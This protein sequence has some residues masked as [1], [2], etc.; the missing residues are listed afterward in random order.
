MK[1]TPHDAS[2]DHFKSFVVCKIIP[3]YLSLVCFKP[4]V[5]IL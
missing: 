2:S 3:L 1:V 5:C 4:P